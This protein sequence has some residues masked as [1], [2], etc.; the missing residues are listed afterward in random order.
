MRRRPSLGRRSSCRLR[1]ARRTRTRRAWSPRSPSRCGR[2]GWRNAWP[3]W[4]G[5]SRPTSPRSSAADRQY[6]DYREQQDHDRDEEA[7]VGAEAG[8]V[9]V[10]AADVVLERVDLLLH[11]AALDVEALHLVA[12]R[13]HLLLGGGPLVLLARHV[14][15]ERLEHVLQLLHLLAER[16]LRVG[17]LAEEGT[18]LLGVRARRRRPRRGGGAGAA[19]RLL[20]AFLRAGHT[21]HEREQADG[22]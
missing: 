20:L 3:A 19:R 12:Q 15:A 18:I 4:R 17:E 11:P 22:E 14:G 1:S 16:A 8:D 5:V 21:G 6:E 7:R 10:D 2:R 13:L 9:R